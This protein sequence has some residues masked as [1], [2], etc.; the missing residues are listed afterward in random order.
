MSAET[1]EVS[2]SD[3]KPRTHWIVDGDT[4]E[5]L[6]RR[7]LGDRSR[8]REIRVAN[9]EVLTTDDLLPIGKEILIPPRR[10]LNPPQPQPSLDSS[11]PVAGESSLVPIPW[12]ESPTK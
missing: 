1:E 12:K 6:A 11:V 3:T 10:P 5:E 8:W 9:P 4:L 2:E 7:F